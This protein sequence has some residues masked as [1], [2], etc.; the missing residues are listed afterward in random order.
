MCVKT[1]LYMHDY[2]VHT[3]VYGRDKCDIDTCTVSM[4]SILPPESNTIML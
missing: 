2:H 3:H 4:H 1:V